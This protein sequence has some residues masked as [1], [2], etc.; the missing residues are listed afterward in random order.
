MAHMKGVLSFLYTRLE[1]IAGTLERVKITRAKSESL[2]SSEAWKP[3][4]LR[5]DAHVPVVVGSEDATLE[6]ENQMLENGLQT[7]GDAVLET[8]KRLRSVA[9]LHQMFATRVL[10]QTAD[11]DALYDAAV[12]ATVHAKRAGEHIRKATSGGADFR[13]AVITLLV[14][15]SLSLLFLDWL[16][17]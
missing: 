7:L 13:I 17:N 4:R 8:E 9:E 3:A 2:G 5:L 12:S 15:A 1:D 10:A 6:Q 14:F 11:I 16:K